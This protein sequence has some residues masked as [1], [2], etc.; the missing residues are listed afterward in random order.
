ME[1]MGDMHDKAE[2]QTRRLTANSRN[3]RKDFPGGS[4]V[5]IRL[6]TQETRVQS[7]ILEDPTCLGATKPVQYDY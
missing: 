2:D 5:R 3:S 6:L 7:L 4:M 1:Y